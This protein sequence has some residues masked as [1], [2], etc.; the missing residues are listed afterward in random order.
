MSRGPSHE[1]VRKV[2]AWCLRGAEI[3]GTRWQVTR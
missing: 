3:R 1:A 2:E